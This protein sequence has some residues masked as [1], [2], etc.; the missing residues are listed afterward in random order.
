MRAVIQRVANANVVVDGAVTG[1]VA[2][3]FMVLLGVTHADSE[4]E[5][6]L[7]AGKVAKL[8]V[9]LDAD[10]KMN[11]A[12]GDVGGEVL[13]ISQ[14]TL[15]GDASHGNRPSFIQAARPEQ[16]NPLYE[17]FCAALAGYGLKVEKGV[18]GAHMEVTLLNDGPVTII[19]DTDDLKNKRKEK[20]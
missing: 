14:F 1:A 13:V 4:E 5:A 8:R 10:G 2:K 16:A 7:L 11:L 15:Y 19:L 12:L 17:Y 18:F 3:G 20:I 9:F 6:K